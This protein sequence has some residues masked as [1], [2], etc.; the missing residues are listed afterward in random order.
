TKGF[1]C[2]LRPQ[3]KAQRYQELWPMGHCRNIKGESHC[4]QKAYLSYKSSNLSYRLFKTASQRLGF[5]CEDRSTCLPPSLLCNG[6]L[7]C[8]HGEDESAT[9]CQT[10][11]SLSQNLIF[12]CPNQK[13]WTYVD[14]VC[15]TRN[16]CEDCSDESVSQCPKCSGYRC[17]TVFFAD[18][19][20]IPRTRCKDG[21]Q[22][23]ADWSHEN[24]C[25]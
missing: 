7:D 19:A 21:S 25:E 14:K 1:D 10:P 3:K 4:L 11:S 15:D 16:D 22:D 12:K 2:R 24:L 20:C 9:Y 23:C 18:C 8:S 6:R 5:L 17:D 13:T